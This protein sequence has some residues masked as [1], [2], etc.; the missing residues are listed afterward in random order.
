MKKQKYLVSVVCGILVAGGLAGCGMS[1]AQSGGAPAVPGISAQEAREAGGAPGAQEPQEA[2]G[3][4]GAQEPQE[5]G[6]VP[7]AREPREAGGVPESP[8]SQEATTILAVAESDGSGQTESAYEE[9]FQPY[10]KFG[11]VYHADKNELKYNGK[12][13]RWFED[14][15]PIPDEGQAGMDFFNENGVVDVHAIRDLSSFVRS[16]DGSF[17]PSGKLVGLEAFSEEE[18]AA[19]DIEALKNPPRQTTASSGEPVSAKEREKML[20]EYAPF[21]L[22]YDAK[23]D[24]WYLGDEK[25]RF[26]RD[27]L[28][29][30]GESLT[31]GKFKGALRTFESA[32]GG[33]IDIYTIRDF[34]NPNADGYGTLTGIEK[35]SQTEFDE[36][37]QSSNEVQSSS[38]SCTVTQ[39]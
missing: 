27:V 1:A 21:G 30:N 29:S 25:V 20:Q 28:I 23:E 4:P 33:T 38:G 7:G 22:T 39:E 9:R 14:Y 19:R 15:Y 13:V 31:G 2:G 10:E 3:A 26:C 11:L 18:F 16:E 8:E 12:S 5:A 6:G 35:Y 36:H 17:D 32:K 37:T 34:A 24:Q